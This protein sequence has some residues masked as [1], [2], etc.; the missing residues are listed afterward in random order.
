[1][2]IDAMS[3]TLILWSLL[4]LAFVVFWIIALIRIMK[5]EFP[6]QHEKLIWALL[7]IFVPLIGTII[8]FTVGRSREISN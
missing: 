1:M 8:Y 4:A 2:E 7:I 6:G 3:V 5:N